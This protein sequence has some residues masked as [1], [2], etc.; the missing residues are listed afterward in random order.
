VKHEFDGACAPGHAIHSATW[1]TFSVGCYEIVPR[2]SVT[3]T[4]RGPVKVRVIGPV[5][6]PHDVYTKASEICGKLDDG[7]YWGPKTVRVK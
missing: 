3:G 6:R 4:K 2:K 7:T 5:S 1:K